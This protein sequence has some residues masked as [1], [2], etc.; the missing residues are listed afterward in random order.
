MD[1]G[2]AEAA[3]PYFECVRSPAVALDLTVESE[4]VVILV[5]NYPALSSQNYEPRAYQEAFELSRGF[6]ANTW[7]IEAL[8]GNKDPGMNPIFLGRETEKTSWHAIKD[9]E[10][11]PPHKESEQETEADID[12]GA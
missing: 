5:M 9:S 2:E 12:L 7:L 6:E 1:E 10:R 11:C 8:E 4:A 3:T